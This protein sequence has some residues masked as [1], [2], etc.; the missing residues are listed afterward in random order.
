MGTVNHTLILL[1]LIFFHAKLGLDVCPRELGE[2]IDVKRICLTLL[3]LVTHICINFSTVYN[4]T[5]VAKGLIRKINANYSQKIWQHRY[6]FKFLF[7]ALFPHK[8]QCRILHATHSF[9]ETATPIKIR[10]DV[11]TTSHTVVC[12]F[13]LGF[14]TDKNSR[15]CTE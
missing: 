13:Y 12:R 2:S 6:T 8:A 15:F 14:S 9:A 5:L 1:L 3:L 11:T 7:S 4:D 10:N